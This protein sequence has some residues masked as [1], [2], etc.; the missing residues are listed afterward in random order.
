[1]PILLLHLYRSV[2]QESWATDINAALI[3]RFYI[4]RCIAPTLPNRKDA[5][6]VRAV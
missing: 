1:M 2:L 3:L 5:F 6:H 4:D